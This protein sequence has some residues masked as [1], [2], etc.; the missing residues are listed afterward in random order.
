LSVSDPDATSPISPQELTWSYRVDSSDWKSGGSASTGTNTLDPTGFVSGFTIPGTSHTL[1]LRV[2]DD[3]EYSQAVAI[4]YSVPPADPLV[5]CNTSACEEAPGSTAIG[6]IDVSTESP[7][8]AAIGVSAESRGN[9]G[10]AGL[11][12]GVVVGVLGIAVAAVVVI[13]YVVLP[14]L[15]AKSAKNDTCGEPASDEIEMA[16]SENREKFGKV[17]GE[18]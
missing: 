14:K 4:A 1:F 15:N 16:D 12:V 18:G 6:S 8:S 3:F 2:Y 9:S 11:I 17:N 7:G 10:N 5:S 13:V